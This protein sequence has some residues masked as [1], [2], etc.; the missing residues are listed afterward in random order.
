M[1]SRRVAAIVL[2]IATPLIAAC[3]SSDSGGA[4]ATSAPAAAAT[5]PSTDAPSSGGGI[6]GALIAGAE[7]IDDSSSAVC[8]INRQTLQT[9]SDAYLA[10]NG[11]F[12]SS[13]SDL[14]GTL[15]LEPVPGYDFAADGTVQPL[16]DGPCLGH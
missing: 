14:V 6:A 15:I 3:S 10:L 1:T 12:P 7:G 4:T 8:D 13:Q 2:L 11:E 16:A 5:T 9:A